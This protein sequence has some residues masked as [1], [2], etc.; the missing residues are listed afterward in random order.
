MKVMSIESLFVWIKPD[1]VDEKTGLVFFYKQKYCL[2][3][4]YYE[5]ILLKY[6]LLKSLI[7]YYNIY[8]KIH[9]FIWYIL[10]NGKS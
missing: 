6:I 5:C 10:K 4:I 7:H 8:L 1:H 2:C 3:L 9:H